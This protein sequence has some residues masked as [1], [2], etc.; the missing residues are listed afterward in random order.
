MAKPI[1]ATPTLVGKE[2]DMFI[3]KMM[4]VESSRLTA[5]QKREAIKIRENMEILTIC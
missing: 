4:N 3:E 2:A 5:K 1:K